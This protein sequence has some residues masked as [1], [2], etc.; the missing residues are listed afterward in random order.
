M[1]KVLLVGFKGKNNSSSMLVEQLSSDHVLLTNSFSRLKKDIESISTEYECVLMFGVDKNLSSSVRIETCAGKDGE[2]IESV[3]K[4]DTF[5]K[6]FAGEGILPVISDKPTVYLCNEAYWYVLRKFSGR[7]LFIHIP[8]IKY[9][10]E[11]FIGKVKHAFDAFLSG[12]KK[13]EMNR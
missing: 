7:A 11:Q 9:A 5:A 8:T 2:T 12:G 10:D 6:A 3:L 4:T 13:P 1:G